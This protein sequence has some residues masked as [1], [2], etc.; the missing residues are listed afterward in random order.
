M[1]CNEYLCLVNYLNSPTT[2]WC[3]KA[4]VTMDLEHTL[5]CEKALRKHTNNIQLFSHPGVKRK[6]YLTEDKRS[7][8][9][10]YVMKGQRW[11]IKIQRCLPAGTK[12]VMTFTASLNTPSS[13]AKQRLLSWKNQVIPVK[14]S[15]VLLR[16]I[17]TQYA[18]LIC[19]LIYSGF[20]HFLTN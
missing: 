7:L 20:R 8:L 9:W 18:T 19:I 5:I 3:C 12:W 15:S 6:V 13:R 10:L 16:I 14:T 1:I 17:L 2:G 11:N 4:T